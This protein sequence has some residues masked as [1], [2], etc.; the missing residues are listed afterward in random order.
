MGF[1]KVEG[2]DDMFVFPSGFEQNLLF[3]KRVRGGV[4]PAENRALAALLIDAEQASLLLQVIEQ[5]NQ[6]YKFDDIRPQTILGNTHEA[7]SALYSLIDNV[8]FEFVS[9]S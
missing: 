3:L 9:S 7:L 6:L 5:Y 8:K 4:Q 1:D 2:W